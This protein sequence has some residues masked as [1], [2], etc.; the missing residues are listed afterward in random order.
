MTYTPKSC[1]SITLKEAK[2]DEK[3]LQE[4]I[5][6]NPSILGLGDTVIIE[7]ERVQLSG[8]RLDFLLREP[9]DNTRYVVEVMLGPLDASHIIRTIEYWD[10]EKSRYPNIKHRAVIIAEEITARFFNVIALLHRSVPLIAIQLSAF[11]VEADLFIHFTRVLDFVEPVEDEEPSGG[12]QKG[13]DYWLKANP[14]FIEIFDKIL[15]LISNARVTYNQGHIALGTSGGNFSWFHPRRKANLYW[16]IDVKPENRA[17]WLER[18]E[19]VG[20]YP[21]TSNNE[22]TVGLPISLEDTAK[23]SDLISEMLQEADKYSEN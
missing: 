8:G 15:T 7:K 13:R 12:T 18:L 19:S 9:N 16:E 4:Q 17:K 20:F 22:T 6:S 10:I 5:R 2:L 11:T 14:V 21:N 1:K 23:H 3:W